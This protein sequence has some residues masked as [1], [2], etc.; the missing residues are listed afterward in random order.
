MI[1]DS[2]RTFLRL[3]IRTLNRNYKLRRCI[4]NNIIKC[5]CP[6]FIKDYWDKYEKG[7]KDKLDK[8]T[9]NMK[10]QKDKVMLI[11]ERGPNAFNPVQ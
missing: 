4:K 7:N 9:D 1:F 2:M 3:I 5:C 10:K 6:N 8:I 11:K